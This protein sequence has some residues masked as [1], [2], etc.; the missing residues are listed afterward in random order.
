MRD[1]STRRRTHTILCCFVY[2]A[3]CS[4][5]WSQDKAAKD[6]PEQ[7]KVIAHTVSAKTTSAGVPV[8]RVE[9]EKRI[10][11]FEGKDESKLAVGG[12]IPFRIEGDW[13]YVRQGD[14]QEKFRVIDTQLKDDD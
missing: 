12:T 8:Y 11:E 2:L 6:Y 5:A 14:K 3:A 13:A 4:A 1:S 7:G 10:Y 9:T